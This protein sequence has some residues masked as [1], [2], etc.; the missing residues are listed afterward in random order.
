MTVRDPSACLASIVEIFGD[1]GLPG[2]LVGALAVKRYRATPR[3][4]TVADTLAEFDSQVEHRLRTAGYVD[5][6]SDVG[7]AAQETGTCRVKNG[8]SSVITVIA[9]RPRPVGRR[10]R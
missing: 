3:F 6:F 9:Y 7:E 2:T 8:A 10:C 4:T 1:L 5:V